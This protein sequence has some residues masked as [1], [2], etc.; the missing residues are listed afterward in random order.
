MSM[1]ISDP[2]LRKSE[3]IFLAALTPYQTIGAPSVNCRW[4]D[5]VTIGRGLPLAV[6]H[7][8]AKVVKSVTF[9]TGGSPSEVSV[10]KCPIFLSHTYF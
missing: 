2:N 10:R 8:D 5:Q 9:H 7:E 4:A 6:M 3:K 1:E